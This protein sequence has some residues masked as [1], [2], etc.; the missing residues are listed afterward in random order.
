MRS[1]HIQKLIP[2]AIE[3]AEKHLVKDKIISSE[4]NGYISS[5]GASI[6]SAGL[7][8][9]VIFYSQKGD[10]NE[11]QKI[12]AALEEILRKHDYENINLLNKTIELFKA[13]NQQ[14]K[15]NRLTEKI[16]DAAIALKLAIRI[17][18]KS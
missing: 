11:R 17:F 3:A 13:D 2:A 15:I 6:I 10:S 9:T 18:P 7:L 4:F 5:F 1:K 8:P 14:D 12:I 16:S